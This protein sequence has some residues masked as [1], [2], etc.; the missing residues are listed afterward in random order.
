M[1]DMW[2]SRPPPLPLD[3]DAIKN[4]TFV[5][6][7]EHGVTRVNGKIR[8]AV[9]EGKQVPM[10]GSVAAA[11]GGLKDQRSLTLGDNLGLFISRYMSVDHPSESLWSN[12]VH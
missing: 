2:R 3:F 1:S 4:G 6:K 8:G 12:G 9:S 5:L 7:E 11:N 10:N